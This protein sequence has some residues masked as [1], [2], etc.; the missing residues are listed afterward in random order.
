MV[1]LGKAAKLRT[2]AGAQELVDVRGSRGEIAV[3]ERL[4][5]LGVER[6]LLRAAVRPSARRQR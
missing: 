3:V 1:N 2:I 5:L 4:G 6:A